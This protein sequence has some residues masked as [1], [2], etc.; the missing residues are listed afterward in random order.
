MDEQ[1]NDI[2]K[3]SNALEA[4]LRRYMLPTHM[5]FPVL[6]RFEDQRS[7]ESA[8]IALVC[9]YDGLKSEYN[10][11]SHA[12]IAANDLLDLIVNSAM[13]NGDKIDGLKK[14]VEWPEQFCY[15]VSKVNET[16]DEDDASKRLF[17]MTI[18]LR[19]VEAG[20]EG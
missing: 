11:D 20:E 5:P 18:M 3:F 1:E 10:V 4:N 7:S 6:E 17:D 14:R 12:Q 2:K 13:E 8:Y 15:Y 16:E 9:P 19:F